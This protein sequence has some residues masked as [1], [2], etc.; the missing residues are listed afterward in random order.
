[1]FTLK[2]KKNPLK[3]SLPSNFEH[4]VHTGFDQ[5]NGKFVG[6]PAQWNGIV[7]TN[8]VSPSFDSS[9]GTN[10]YQ[11]SNHKNGFNTHEPNR[12]KPMVDPSIITPMEILN[13]KTLVKGEDSS[14]ALN[15][16]FTE[17]LDNQNYIPTSVMNGYY[18]AKPHSQDRAKKISIVRSNSL[19]R[20]HSL[21]EKPFEQ[22]YLIG[23]GIPHN[24]KNNSNPYDEEIN[25]IRIL[26]RM[27][28]NG[29]IP[30]SPNICSGAALGNFPF[31][32]L[33]PVPSLLA[34]SSN[35]HTHS[36]SKSSSTQREV[37]GT[38]IHHN[39]NETP[40]CLQNN[41]VIHKFSYSNAIFNN[42][43]KI[44]YPDA[45]ENNVLSSAQGH[46]HKNIDDTAC[47]QSQF[48]VQSSSY[49]TQTS[50]YNLP[51]RLG[52]YQNNILVYDNFNKV[53]CR[54]SNPITNQH[55][56]NPPKF[57]NDLKDQI[58]VLDDFNIQNRYYNNSPNI[59]NVTP[60]NQIKDKNNLDYYSPRV[61]SHYSSR[62][63]DNVQQ[64]K[65]YIAD[66]AN[67]IDSIV[68]SNYPYLSMSIGTDNTKLSSFNDIL[69]NGG[70]SMY[71][72]SSP[73]NG[74]INVDSPVND[75][76]PN[77]NKTVSFASPLITVVDQTNFFGAGLL[78]NINFN[79][80]RMNDCGSNS[81]S[82]DN[83]G[84]TLERLRQKLWD[85]TITK[86][87]PPSA[88]MTNNDYTGKDAHSNSNV[89]QSNKIPG[90]SSNVSNSSQMVPSF[91]FNNITLFNGHNNR[92]THTPNQNLLKNSSFK[93][94][95]LKKSML[96]SDMN[97]SKNANKVADKNNVIL[98]GQ[99]LNLNNITSSAS[100]V[101]LSHEEFKRTLKL[102]VSNE[103]DTKLALESLKDFKRIGE[104]STGTVYLAIEK[105]SISSNSFH[106]NHNSATEKFKSSNPMDRY[107]RSVAVKKMDL[108][109]QQ[110]RELLFNEVAIM[111]DY[112]HPCIVEMYGSYLVGEELWVVMELMEGGPLTDIVLRRATQRNEEQIATVCRSCLKAL[113]FLHSQGVIHRD[114]KSDSILLTKDGRVKLSDFGFC[115]QVSHQCPKRKSLVGTPYWMSP[116]VIGRL[117]YGP[118]VDIW[119]LGVMVIEMVDGEPPFFDKLPLQAMRLI[120]DTHPPKP[121]NCDKLSLRLL[122]FLEL[123]LIRDPHDRATAQELLQHPF[124]CLAGPPESLIPLMQNF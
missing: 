42:P 52:N 110:R 115:A 12:P 107:N 14:I 78:D 37:D 13:L 100:G 31:S 117:P 58:S 104:G 118:E 91:H 44:N 10:N 35:N 98:N 97:V 46:N 25:K 85:T 1:M 3:I 34:P 120:R 5:F 75:N 83:N 65:H 39:Q 119:S 63:E 54:I 77:F 82:L 55:F 106:S 80:N 61:L 57:A 84:G 89:Y 123:M 102:V 73:L 87:K 45:F 24:D 66:R 124:V 29:L 23:S 60:N 28:Y 18:D 96:V 88:S 67:C 76:S 21:T 64:T 101:K 74:V 105:S 68:E 7:D 112:P 27:G 72:V 111:R 93:D 48:Q 92:S 41:N 86:P 9:N 26:N 49:P 71:T 38:V 108:R 70:S 114:I 122:N 32:Y 51:Q 99:N 79:S 90:N 103:R 95:I 53:S 8:T 33:H 11:F 62:D 20:D 16:T 47:H 36:L 59:H 69:S 15:Q 40:R 17:G 116:E 56:S 50:I 81:N 94:G 6:L 2:K 43:W 22:E 19:R 30:K 109:K 113:A 121:K 4:R